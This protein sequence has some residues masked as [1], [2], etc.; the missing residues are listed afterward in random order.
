VRLL[1]LSNSTHAELPFLAHA[2]EEIRRFLGPGP[3]R[4]LF[5][6]HASV[7]FSFD[8]YTHTVNAALE[9]IELALDGV[10]A[11]ADARA[12]L[13]AAPAVVIGGGNTFHLLRELRRLELLEP[14]AAQVR[15]GTPYVGWSAGANLACPTIRTTNDMPIVEPGGME[16]LG[17]VPFQINP[18]YTNACVP[19]HR[20]ETR[21]QRI[22]EFIEVNHDV[23]VLGLREGSMLRIEGER[24]R[25]LGPR[26]V[27]LFRHGARPREYGAADDLSFLLQE[28]RPDQAPR[29]HRHG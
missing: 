26:R 15:A 10:H 17:L 23:P 19:R 25:L 16:A 14:I 20:G 24:M 2:R 18:H 29:L 3:S 12:A 8:D 27:R 21:D 28:A 9:G 7:R 13:Q 11:V 1:L 5:V 6:P 4:G 22:G